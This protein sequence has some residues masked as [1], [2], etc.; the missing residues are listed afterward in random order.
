[1]KRLS[2]E[3]MENLQGGKSCGS[4]ANK[5]IAIMGGAA[6]LGSFITIGGIALGA[7]AFGPSAVFLAGVGIYCAFQN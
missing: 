6:T 5:A 1:M 2:F 4:T 3:Q 7:I